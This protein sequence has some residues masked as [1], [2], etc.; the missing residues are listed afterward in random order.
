MAIAERVRVLRES[1]VSAGSVGS[2]TTA[3]SHD[4][5]PVAIGPGEG[6]VLRDCVRRE[7]A[8]SALEV[9]LLIR[10]ACADAG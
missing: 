4:L 1:I 3:R 6:V 9:G 2:R 7:R 10:R 8:A 5:F